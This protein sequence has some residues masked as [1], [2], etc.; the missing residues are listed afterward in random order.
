MS[1]YASHTRR[2]V[3]A[4]RTTNQPIGRMASPETHQEHRQKTNQDHGSPKRGGQPHTSLA[5]L[6]C[7]WAEFARASPGT[8]KTIAMLPTYH[9]VAKDQG[10]PYPFAINLHLSITCRYLGSTYNTNELVFRHFF[11][12]GHL[13]TRELLQRY[14]TEAH[15]AIRKRLGVNL[16]YTNTLGDTVTVVTKKADPHQGE[17][18]TTG[19]IGVRFPIVRAAGTAYEQ[20]RNQQHKRDSQA[21]GL[22]GH[23]RQVCP[24]LIPK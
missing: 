23:T 1:S 16:S 24:T 9:T 12:A 14:R 20:Q 22:L 5:R 17:W 21:Y 6:D 8:N 7:T 10:Y 15:A 18:I 19:D 11:P 4:R 3:K 13:A 2:G